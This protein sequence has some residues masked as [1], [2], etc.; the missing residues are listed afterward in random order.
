MRQFAIFVFISLAAV[1]GRAETP[2]EAVLRRWTELIG[3]HGFGEVLSAVMDD[4]TLEWPAVHSLAFPEAERDASLDAAY[5]ELAGKLLEGM[6]D[7]ELGLRNL[8][9]DEFVSR[10]G[11]MLALRNRLATQRSYANLL[12]ADVINRCVAVNVGARLVREPRV[13]SGLLEIQEQL[14][15][16]TI[17]TDS[18]VALTMDELGL[19]AIPD[20][21]ERSSTDFERLAALWNYLEPGVPVGWP[22]SQSFVDA[23][24]MMQSR[25]LLGLAC[26]LVGTDTLI[27]THLPSLV[28]YRERVQAAPRGASYREI[29][30]ALGERT[31][32]PES[33]GTMP[34]GIRRAASA[35]SELE[36]EVESG[37]IWIR[38]AFTAEQILDWHN[39]R[40]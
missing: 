7:F 14:A 15:H 30:L 27:H 20:A 5:R 33:L 3:E 22:G 39:V 6:Q 12:L 29:K 36:Q 38:P 21:L 2:G 9:Q 23:D 31:P 4:S 11:A 24:T 18:L 40:Q 17:S 10:A 34:Y 13:G 1:L 37:K 35:V 8:S 26:R 19:K 28:L 25:N 16:Y 32:A